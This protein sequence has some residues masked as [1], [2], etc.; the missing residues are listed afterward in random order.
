MQHKMTKSAQNNH[1]KHTRYV[2]NEVNKTLIF[3]PLY[4]RGILIIHNNNYIQSP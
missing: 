2:T 4:T 1:Q 3:N